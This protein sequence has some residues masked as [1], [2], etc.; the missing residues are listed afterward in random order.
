MT[1]ERS[2][3]TSA[4]PQKTQSAKGAKRPIQKSRAKAQPAAPS[5]KLGKVIAL[6]KRPKGATIADLVKATDWQ[7]H[8]V[9]GAISGAIKKKLKLTVVSEKTG[10]V[11][12]YRIKA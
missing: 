2:K 9:R 4:V 3:T 10:D 1:T 8:S 6:L 11:R 12:T 7:A 5:G